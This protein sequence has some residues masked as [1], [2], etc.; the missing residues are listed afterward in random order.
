MEYLAKKQQKQFKESI[1]V[2]KMCIIC[3][4]MEKNKL[5]PWEA[6]K[7]LSEMREEIGTEHTKEVEE[8]ISM[9]IYEQLHL[10]FGDFVLKEQKNEKK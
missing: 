7:N 4:E 1:M 8:K 9:A 5:T 2:N 3:V 6:K 10:E